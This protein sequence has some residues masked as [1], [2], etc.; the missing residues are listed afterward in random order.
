MQKKLPLPTVNQKIL[1][2]TENK[3]ALKHVHQFFK[4]VEKKY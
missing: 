1:F 3:N 4:H 2:S